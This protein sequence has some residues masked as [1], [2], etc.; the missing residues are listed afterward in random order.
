M[1]T[2]IRRPLYELLVRLL[3][4][5]LTRNPA[6]RNDFVAS[7]EAALNHDA[8]DRLG[9][10]RARTL[11]IGG[12]EDRLFPASVQKDTARRIPGASLRLIQGTG[13]GAFDERK[14]EFDGAVKGFCR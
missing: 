6:A 12:A 10:I 3:G 5:G 11:V 9:Q 4:R 7:A 8:G 2:G 13:H 1:Y 14:R